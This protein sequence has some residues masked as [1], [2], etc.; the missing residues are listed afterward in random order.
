[1]R[2][3]RDVLNG[4]ASAGDWRGRSLVTCFMVKFRSL[5]VDSLEMWFGAESTILLTTDLFRLDLL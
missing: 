5:L 2:S 4:R 3:V 1:M